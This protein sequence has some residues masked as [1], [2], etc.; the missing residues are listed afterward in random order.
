MSVAQGRALPALSDIESAAEIVYRAMPPT[1]QYR[2]PLLERRLGVETWVKH[3]NHT[4]VGAFKVRGGL[5]HLDAIARGATKPKGVVAATRG[6][7]GQSVAF[8]AARAGIA[9]TIVVPHGNSRDKNAAMQALGARLIERGTEFQES[10]EHSRELARREGLQFV[11]S[12]HPDLVRGVATYALEFLRAANPLDAVYVPIG[13]GSGIC[14]MLAARDALGLGTEVV[15]VAAERAPAIAES[16]REGRIVEAPAPTFADGMACRRPNDDAFAV[17]SDRRQRV[18]LVSDEAI[19]DAMRA[20]YADTHNAVE[21]A[22]AASLAAA[23]ADARERGYRRIGLVISGANI[24]A[25][26]FAR[27]L[28]AGTT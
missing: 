7:H 2:W 12:F 4:P 14:G 26:E 27:V 17:L 3:E 23:S 6:N 25:A 13:L 11:P 1:P 24:D 20:L 19:E 21:G 28:G 9:C 15:G 10:L 8:A 18:V 22:G 5:V 16:L